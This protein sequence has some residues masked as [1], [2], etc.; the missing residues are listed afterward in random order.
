MNRQ[1]IHFTILLANDSGID[2]RFQKQSR[3]WNCDSF[4]IGIGT[5]PPLSLVLL[6]LTLSLSCRRA[7]CRGSFR[8]GGNGSDLARWP[9]CSAR[10]QRPCLVVR[11]A[12]TLWGVISGTNEMNCQSTPKLLNKTRAE[13][14]FITNDSELIKKITVFGQRID[15]LL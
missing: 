14:I 7:F 2:S 11:H 12:W 6:I 8:T 15:Y 13:S 5:A 9:L 10:A 1:T 3:N 4:G